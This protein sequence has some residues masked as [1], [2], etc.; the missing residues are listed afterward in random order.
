M[1]NV[2]I[3]W[4]QGIFVTKVL[5]E[6]PAFNVLQPGDKILQVCH[7]QRMSDMLTSMDNPFDVFPAWITHQI[8]F[9]LTISIITKVYSL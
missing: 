9:H 5:Q 3:F 7:C 6:G 8:S 2:Y 1:L 4:F